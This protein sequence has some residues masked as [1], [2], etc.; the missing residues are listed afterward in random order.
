MLRTTTTGAG[1]REQL[2][3]SSGV[4][5]GSAEVRVRR[6]SSDESSTRYNQQ[7]RGLLWWH[8]QPG[9]L[10]R[11]RRVHRYA[12]RAEIRVRS[13]R[14]KECMPLA[15]RR[16]GVLAAMRMC[17][18]DHEAQEDREDAN[19]LPHLQG[20]G[21]GHAGLRIEAPVGHDVSSMTYLASVWTPACQLRAKSVSI[22]C[23][24]QR[25]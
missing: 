25:P 21:H 6:R 22:A 15:L 7:R 23:R 17:R 14:S 4:R 11:A 2:S 18:L 24:A 13:C 3:L 8:R 9:S 20:Q 10:C 5:W 16:N 19:P 1:T 12:K